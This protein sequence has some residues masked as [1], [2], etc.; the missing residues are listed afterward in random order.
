MK[1]TENTWP[2]T[3]IYELLATS[4]GKMHLR[5]HHMCSRGGGGAVVHVHLQGEK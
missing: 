1:S 4:K 5:V 3:T 2:E